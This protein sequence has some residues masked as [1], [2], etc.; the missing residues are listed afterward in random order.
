MFTTNPAN[1][2]P[3]GAEHGPLDPSG[4]DNSN[5]TGP[6]PTDPSLTNLFS[7][8]LLSDLKLW[9]PWPGYGW[10]WP[11]PNGPGFGHPGHGEWS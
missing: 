7:E 10:P 1:M 9:D 4:S 11:R 2:A 5:P 6:G 8:T 3:K